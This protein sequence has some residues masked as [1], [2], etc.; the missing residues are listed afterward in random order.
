MG[1]GAA[2]EGAAKDT[3]LEPRPELAYSKRPEPGFGIQGT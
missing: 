3:Y 2:D 1:G